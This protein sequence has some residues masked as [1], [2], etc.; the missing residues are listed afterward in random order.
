ML[1]WK[2]YHLNLEFGDED[3]D[4]SLLLAPKVL[5]SV[6]QYAKCRLSYNLLLST[7]Y[8]AQKCPYRCSIH[9]KYVR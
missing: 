6:N 4:Y 5:E 9:F 2:V 8:V 3:D 7:D 1:T